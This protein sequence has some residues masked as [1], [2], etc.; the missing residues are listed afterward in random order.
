MRLGLQ[1][2][3]IG[4]AVV[5]AA[6]VTYWVQGP[7]D[8]SVPCDPALLP[9]DEVC[10]ARVLGEWGGD[11]LWVDARTRAEWERDSLEGSVLWS[12][13]PGED[14]NAF[15]MQVAEKMLDGRRVVVFCANENCGVS[16]EVAGRIRKLDLGNEIYVLHGG[17][18]ALVASPGVI[19]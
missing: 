16:R 1:L 4:V 14:M 5:L 18:R 6:G 8:R 11:V 3:A 15:E 13:E 7:P 12:T 10:L 2:L 9:A 17:W 19:K